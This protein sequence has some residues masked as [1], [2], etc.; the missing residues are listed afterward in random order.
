MHTT[1]SKLRCIFVIKYDSSL[2][3]NSSRRASSITAAAAA[4]SGHRASLSPPRTRIDHQLVVCL[5]TLYSA[6]SPLQYIG[7]AS[8]YQKH[9]CIT[10]IFSIFSYIIEYDRIFNNRDIIM[11]INNIKLEYLNFQVLML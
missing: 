2:K 8:G 10:Y 6:Y 5:F 1:W 9:V 3:E 4:G 7:K 11:L